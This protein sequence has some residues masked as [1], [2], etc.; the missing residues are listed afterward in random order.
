[1]K[2]LA[3][4]LLLTTSSAAPGLALAR[5]ATIA[6]KMAPYQ[7]PGAY[8]AI[9]VVGP[10]GKY[11]STLWVAGEKPK[12]QRHLRGW[13]RAYSTSGGSIDA[14]TGAS[15]GSGRTLRIDVDLADALIDAGYEIRVDSAV[16]DGS[17]YSGDAVAPLRSGGSGTTVR[18][19]GYVATFAV[20]M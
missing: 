10:D 15:V 16:E 18:G 5:P 19:T 4:A 14:I 2:K 1:M 12:Y 7:G 9:Y 11:Q 13:S 20:K 8:L 17:D 3:F 6:L